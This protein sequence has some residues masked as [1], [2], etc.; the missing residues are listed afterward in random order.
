MMYY[1]EFR[2]LKQLD[3]SR[4]EL[5][6]TIVLRIGKKFSKSPNKLTSREKITLNNLS[7]GKVKMIYIL[8]SIKSY[9]ALT[10]FK[11]KNAKFMFVK[12]VLPAEKRF[13]A[14]RFVRCARI[15]TLHIN[16]NFCEVKLKW[17][18]KNATGMQE[19]NFDFNCLKPNVFVGLS[20]EDI[21][22]SLRIKLC[23]NKRFESKKEYL[24]QIKKSKFLRTQTNEQNNDILNRNL[25]AL[26][27]L[28]RFALEKISF[29]QNTIVLNGAE[30]QVQNKVFKR[31]L[32]GFFSTHSSNTFG[33]RR[34]ILTHRRA[35]DIMK[36]GINN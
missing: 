27:V 2:S 31:V 13:H 25:V 16:I 34:N 8:P 7:A 17:L 22:S 5:K 20:A 21:P 9:Q 19:M 36:S 32:C 24:V 28:D 33:L 26:S 18:I 29:E 11:N 1:T 15:V 6:S 14:M 4:I 35:F 23:S 12:W 10:F 30:Y 3:N